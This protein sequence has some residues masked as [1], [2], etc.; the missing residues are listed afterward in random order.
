[1]YG[2]VMRPFM[3][4]G[5]GGWGHQR[6]F[7]NSKPQ[8]FVHPKHLRLQTL[9]GVLRGL[10]LSHVSLHAWLMSTTPAPAVTYTGADCPGSAQGL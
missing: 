4:G 7:S 5:M 3:E 1:M 8:V 9:F 2:H 10:D 6:I